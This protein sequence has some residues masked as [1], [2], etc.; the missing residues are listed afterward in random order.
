MQWL[1]VPLL[2]LLPLVPP[3]RDAYSLGFGGGSS[4]ATTL[5]VNPACRWLPSQN[6]LLAEW[7]QRQ[8]EMIVRPASPNGAPPGSTI[9]NSPSMRIGP[10]FCGE[11]LVAIFG[12]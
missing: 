8:S 7:P 3:A 10:L 4:L 2:P 6:G 11:I 9:S 1:A 12:S 5:S